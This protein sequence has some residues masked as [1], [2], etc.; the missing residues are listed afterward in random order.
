V[1]EERS[2]AEDPLGGEEQATIFSRKLD[3]L[4]IISAFAFLLIIVTT[5]FLLLYDS[6]EGLIT[7]I[8]STIGIRMAIDLGVAAVVWFLVHV[9]IELYHTQKHGEPGVFS[10]SL[11]IILYVALTFVFVFVL[12]H[13]VIKYW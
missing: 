5:S 8:S 1:T 7:I 10:S 6:R 12:T 11:L 2:K 13:F 3:I 4:L 9:V